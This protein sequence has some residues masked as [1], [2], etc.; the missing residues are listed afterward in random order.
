MLT[1]PLRFWGW[2]LGRWFSRWESLL[3]GHGDQ[4]PDP[5]T[6][7]KKTGDSHAHPCSSSA[8]G[9]RH[10]D[11]W[12]LLAIQASCRSSEMPCLKGMRREWQRT[13]DIL[14]WTLCVP[15]EAHIHH[16]YTHAHACVLMHTLKNKKLRDIKIKKQFWG[17]SWLVVGFSRKVVSS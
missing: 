6:P 16:A 11:H 4:S 17:C 9:M 5:N 3:S 14:L 1:L 8:L 7:I 2:H 15:I 12:I 10:G 13:P